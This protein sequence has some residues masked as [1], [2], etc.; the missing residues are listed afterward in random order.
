MVGAFP[1]MN[2]FPQE[3]RR[4]ALA[5]AA[6]GAAALPAGCVTEKDGT[7][8][9]DPGKSIQRVDSSIDNF[10]DRTDTAHA[11]DDNSGQ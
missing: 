3:F 6:A 9:F 1:H 2:A 10:L 4:L 7:K 11:G 8:H 5:A